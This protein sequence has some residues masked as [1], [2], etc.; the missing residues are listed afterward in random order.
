MTGLRDLLIEEADDAR[1]YDVTD[2]AVRVVRRQRTA[3]RLVPAAAALIVVAGLI[4]IG[5][6]F[7]GGGDQDPVPAAAGLPAR[8]TPQANP[9]ALPEDRGVGRAAL[10]YLTGDGGQNPWV[11]VTVDGGQYRVDGL[12][13][14]GMSPDGRWLLVLRPDGSRVLRDLAGT[15]RHEFAGA[16]LRSG[17]SW[18]PDSR[19]LVV[20]LSDIAYMVDLATAERSKVPLDPARPD[21]VCAVRNSGVLVLC[22]TLSSGPRLADG[23]TGQVIREIPTAALGLRPAEAPLADLATP[24]LG[25]DDHTLFMGTRDAAMATGSHFLVGFDLD[26][27]L[28]TER[29]P[30]PDQLPAAQ[31]PMN[32]GVEYGQ[33]DARYVLGIHPDGPLLLHLAPGRSDP[34][35]VGSVAIELVARDTGTL[36][37][38]TLVSRPV[39]LIVYPG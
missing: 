6:R 8:L 39:T 31:R 38:V 23:V 14:E 28:L 27:G 37:T 34:F 25:P 7:G 29:Y 11:L 35:T 19:R 22:P 26:T 2:R 9:P 30:L 33:P 36:R 13:V 12:R 4:G 3:A 15:A 10:A 5:V 16:D 32:G 20:Q 17:A 24:M 21:R 1:V 18:S